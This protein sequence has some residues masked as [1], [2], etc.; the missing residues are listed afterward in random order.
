M[1]Q[2]FPRHQAITCELYTYINSSKPPNNPKNSP[3]YYLH[4]VNKE[5]RLKEIKKLATVAQF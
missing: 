1:H 2:A 3:S 4:T 5:L